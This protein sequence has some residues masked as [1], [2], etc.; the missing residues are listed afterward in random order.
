MYI[1]I[2]QGIQAAQTIS[3][4]L[5]KISRPISGPNDVTAYL[6]GWITHPDTGEVALQVDPNQVI[7]VHPSQDTSVLAQLIL[8]DVPQSEIDQLT[9]WLSQ[10]K[11]ITF[12][13]IIPSTITLRGK[14]EMEANGWFNQNL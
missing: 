2:T 6:F 1:I 8:Q 10:Q 11:E 3:R 9:N 4:E 14:A 13:Q 7:P 12:S 5:F